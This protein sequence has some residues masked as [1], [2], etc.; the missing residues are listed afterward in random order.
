MAKERPLRIA[1]TANCQQIASQSST[2]AGPALV[3]PLSGMTRLRWRPGGQIMLRTLEL[4]GALRAGRA[5][6]CAPLVA[7]PSCGSGRGAEPGRR[8]DRRG[9]ALPGTDRRRSRRAARRHGGL[10]GRSAAR[11]GARKGPQAGWPSLTPTE[12][13]VVDLVA[14]GLSN[15]QI[16]ERLY[17]SR[18]TAQT[19]IAHVFAKLDISVRA[20]LAV[21]GDPA[22]GRPAGRPLTSTQQPTGGASWPCRGSCESVDQDDQDDT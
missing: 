4:T 2:P 20:Q 3:R 10:C 12:H 15:P 5:G 6:T 11:R 19:H 21:E 14:D 16:G 9:A 1:L 22:P 8:A 17:I 13:A 7:A 18:R